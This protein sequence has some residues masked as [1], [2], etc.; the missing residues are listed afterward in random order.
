[1][2]DQYSIPE[3]LYYTKEHEWTRIESGI[4]TVGITDYAAKTLNDIVYLSLPS[5]DQDLKQLSSF[6]TVESTKAVSELYAPLSGKVAAVNS[7]LV[8]H[9]E[10][11]NQ[12]PYDQGWIIKIRPSDL[13][14]EKEKLLDSKQYAAFLSSPD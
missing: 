11:V 13:E 2:R 5:P 14:G 12:S 3:D 8:N 6:G 9:P 10:L 1:M 4:V 7:Q